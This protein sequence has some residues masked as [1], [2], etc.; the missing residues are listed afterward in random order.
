V[1][2]PI[3]TCSLHLTTTGTEFSIQEWRKWLQ[4]GNQLPA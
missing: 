3:A 2:T 4:T 1:A